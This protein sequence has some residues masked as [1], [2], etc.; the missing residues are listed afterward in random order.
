MSTYSTGSS[1]G[2]SEGSVSHRSGY[3]SVFRQDRSHKPEDY[4]GKAVIHG[5][6]PV[7]THNHRHTRGLDAR[8]PSPAYELSVFRGRGHE[9]QGRVRD[10]LSIPTTITYEDLGKSQSRKHGGS[11]PAELGSVQE[12]SRERDHDGSNSEQNHEGGSDITVE[13]IDRRNGD[14]NAKPNAYRQLLSQAIEELNGESN[15]LA[16]AHRHEGYSPTPTTNCWHAVAQDI[17]VPI[18][19]IPTIMKLLYILSLRGND[20]SV[21]ERIMDI[22]RAEAGG[23]YSHPDAVA[24]VSHRTW[25]LDGIQE[26]REAAGGYPSI[27]TNRTI[28]TSRSLASRFAAALPGNKTPCSYLFAAAVIGI[29]L[30]FALAIWWWRS[31][32]DLSGGF[33][34]GS[35]IIAV[36]ALVVAVAGKFHA[37]N[38]RCR[39]ASTESND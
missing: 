28:T 3:Y 14:G 26:S 32:N 1:S 17:T 20:A 33:T 2:S 38:C 30:S 21:G 4:K 31:Q 25:P 36:D 35:Y 23:V 7:V 24:P 19:Q 18:Y 39:K 22:C 9:S 10:G 13:N 34:L 29:I 6:P 37:P 12:S 5:K 11:N 27:D 15:M 16:P 8:G